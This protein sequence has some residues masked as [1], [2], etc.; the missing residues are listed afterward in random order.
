MMR[1]PWH[2]KSVPHAVV[3][4]LRG[5][6]CR[7]TNC[8]NSAEPCAKPLDDIKDEARVILSKR[9]VKTISLSGGEP[10]LHPQILDIIT[11]LRREAGVAASMLTNGILFDDMMAGKLRV[12]GLD[13]V[14]FHIQRGQTRPDCDDARV[15]AVR[16][17]KG[18]IARAHGIYPAIVETIRADDAEGFAALGRFLRSATEFEYA[19]V[20]VARDF[21]TIDSTV[22]EPEL[23][24]N[25]MLAALARE[26]YNPSVFVGGS[27]HNDIPRWYVLQSVQ[28]VDSSGCERAWNRVRPGLAERMFLYGYAILCCRSVHWMKSTSAKTKARL[29]IN[30]LLGGHLSTF[31]FALRAILFGWTVLEKHIIVQYPPRSLGDGRIEFCDSCPDATVK[32]GRLSSLCLGDTKVAIISSNIMEKNG[33]L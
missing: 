24:R 2:G 7:C 26:G 14:T 12:A 30:G 13:F 3:D 27:I 33:S 32:D 1:L 17:E 5:C 31:V 8:Y 23:D 29:L 6:N 4:I 20:T 28:A 10:L 16:R 15:E 22:A 21:A 25:P 9:N 19:L 11:Y 18:R